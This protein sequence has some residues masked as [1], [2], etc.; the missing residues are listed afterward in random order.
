MQSAHQLL[1]RAFLSVLCGVRDSGTLKKKKN[2]KVSVFCELSQ[3]HRV[4]VSRCQAL[5][6]ARSTTRDLHFRD[7]LCV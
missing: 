3:A 7:D 1:S 5:C 4:K 6:L 2:H